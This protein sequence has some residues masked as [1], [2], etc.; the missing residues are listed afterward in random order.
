MR[1]NVNFGYGFG[2]QCQ[3]RGGAAG[4]SPVAYDAS[5]DQFVPQ[6]HTAHQP[7]ALRQEPGP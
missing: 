5:G 2:V 7:K 3:P 4:G 1:T 6:G